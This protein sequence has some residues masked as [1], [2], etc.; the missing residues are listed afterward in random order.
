MPEDNFFDLG[1]HSILAAQFAVE[2]ESQTDGRIELNTL[3]EHPVLKDFIDSI[4][5]NR[6]GLNKQSDSQLPSL[7]QLSTWQKAITRQLALL[8]G[9]N[10]HKL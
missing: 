3:F 5:I 1:G 6:A 7:T 4:L 10:S 8:Y 9:G 2:L